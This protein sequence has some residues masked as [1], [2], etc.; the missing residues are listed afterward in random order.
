[1][2]QARLELVRRNAL[3]TQL[4][5]AY[6]YDP[7]YSPTRLESFYERVVSQIG[8]SA[9]KL[10]RAKTEEAFV[11]AVSN[12]PP[13]WG[14]GARSPGTGLTSGLLPSSDRARGG[15]DGKHSVREKILAKA[16]AVAP[17]SEACLKRANPEA[18]SI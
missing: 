11:S 14:E 10:A 9:R 8:I 4:R 5:S 3:M 1:V 18:L 6:L 15:S 17:P 13:R 7:F 12:S 16:K 2:G